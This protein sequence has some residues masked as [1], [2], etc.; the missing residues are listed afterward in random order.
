MLRVWSSSIGYLGNMSLEFREGW[1]PVSEPIRLINLDLS[2]T[3]D[4]YYFFLIQKGRL[5]SQI[6]AVIYIFGND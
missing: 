5:Q 4:L 2:F 1:G 6:V 3:P